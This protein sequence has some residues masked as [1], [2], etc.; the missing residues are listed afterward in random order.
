MRILVFLAVPQNI[1]VIAHAEIYSITE[2]R[3]MNSITEKRATTIES[4]NKI[5]GGQVKALLKQK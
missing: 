3:A 1:P 2:K 4:S 5:A